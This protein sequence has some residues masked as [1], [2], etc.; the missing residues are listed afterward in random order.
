MFSV[1]SLLAEDGSMHKKSAIESGTAS[2]QAR[3]QQSS[4]SAKVAAR[5]ATTTAA[6][7]MVDPLLLLQKPGPGQPIDSI[8]SSYPVLM[9]SGNI[10]PSGI[11]VPDARPPMPSAFL[12]GSPMAAAMFWLH[13]QMNQGFRPSPEMSSGG[14]RLRHVGPNPPRLHPTTHHPLGI[15]APP[16]PPP[17]PT[18][19]IGAENLSPRGSSAPSGGHLLQHSPSDSSPDE[20]KA[21]TSEPRGKCG[22]KNGGEQF[23]E[24]HRIP[25]EA[26]SSCMLRKHKNNRK[27]R[28]PF[29]TQQL[30]ALERKFQHKRYLSIAER[31]EFSSTLKLTEQQ[32]KI[33]FQNRR[34]KAKRQ[35][36]AE[37]EKVIFAHANAA[38]AAVAATVARAGGAGTMVGT[39]TTVT[40]TTASHQTMTSW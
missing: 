9:P 22:R 21:S 34:A 33:W 35:L 40:P 3:R 8:C 31:A 20:S 36:E 1:Q 26:I 27:P 14:V 6:T 23:L 32:V 4:R 39:N 10:F 11:A 29:S 17:A 5:T 13:Q 7:T 18:S 37:E 38:L 30:M 16:P 24:E 2:Q 12:P 28:T 19:S 25:L 15:P